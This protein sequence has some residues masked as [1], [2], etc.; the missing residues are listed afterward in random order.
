MTMMQWDETSDKVS[1]QRP[2][3]EKARSLLKLVELR[4]SKL[5]LFQL[6]TDTTLLTEAYYEI[7]K[8]LIT[9]IM[10]C[11]GWKT[12]SHEL[13]VG[14][15]AKS[16][17]EFSAAEITLIDQLRSIRN[18]IAYRGIMIN[19]EYLTRNQHAITKIIQ[20]LRQTL[21]LRLTGQH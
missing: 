3:F 9:A 18:D 1:K 21:N 6:P 2:D 5:S 17:L 4:E 16:Y 11:D 7:V 20:K 12:T 13:L 8:E 10:N 19:P 14:Y 15:L